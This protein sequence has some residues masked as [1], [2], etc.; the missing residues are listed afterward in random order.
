MSTP[1]TAPSSRPLVKY[2]GVFNGHRLVGAK[3][4]QNLCARGWV[5]GNFPVPFECIRRVVGG[6]EYPNVHFAQQAPDGIFRRTQH[7]IGLVI[8]RPRRF[9]AE[10][11]GN[12]E[13]ALQ[14]Q[15]CPVV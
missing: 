14:F 6:A 12:T 10:Q 2:F 3:S 9:R 13:I 11:Y 5:G 1:A 7:R 4:R 15:V 8:Y